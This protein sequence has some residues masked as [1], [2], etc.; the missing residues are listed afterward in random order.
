MCRISQL[1]FTFQTAAQSYIFSSSRILLKGAKKGKWEE[2]GGEGNIPGNSTTYV[3]KTGENEVFISLWYTHTCE[4]DQAFFFYFWTF[5]C[6][7][8]KTLS[9]LYS[10]KFILII[11]IICMQRFKWFGLNGDLEW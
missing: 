5:T 9:V 1:R 10:A 8:K 11:K 3:Q 6:D 4:R 7:F 2:G